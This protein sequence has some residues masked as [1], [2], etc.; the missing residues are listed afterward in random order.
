MSRNRDLFRFKQ[1]SVSHH[2]SSMK[3][4]VDAVILGAWCDVAN[5]NAILDVGC[6]CGVIALMI[7]QRNNSACITGIDIDDASV[8]ESSENFHNSPW[9]A[10]VRAVCG[11][12][13]EYSWDGRYDLIL[14]NPPYFDSGVSEIGTRRERARHQGDLSPYSLLS[15]GRELLNDNG[16]VCMVIP[17]EQREEI[18]DF[19]GAEGFILH[20]ELLVSGR[21]GKAYKRCFLDFRL[22]LGMPGNEVEEAMR[23]IIAIETEEGSFTEEYV[24]LC[25]DFYLKF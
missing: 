4:G 12:F 1:F 7:A 16:S 6:G 11:N 10:R 24:S 17:Y 2:R 5:R 3:V 21:E 25:R 20:R 9:H 23:E 19:A 22:A 15:K 14:S 8:M 13:L 18:V